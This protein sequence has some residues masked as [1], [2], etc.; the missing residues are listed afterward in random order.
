MDSFDVLSVD[1]LLAC[2]RKH[3]VVKATVGQWAFEF[4]PTEPELAAP[5][6]DEQLQKAEEMVR[7]RAG[8]RDDPRHIRFPGS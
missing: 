5:S 7:A 4:A 6:W 1:E 8:Q 3:G 2:L